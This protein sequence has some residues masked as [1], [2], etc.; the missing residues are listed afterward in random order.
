MEDPVRSLI[1]ADEN[2]D[3]ARLIRRE[4]EDG[5]SL[6]VAHGEQIDINSDLNL[7]RPILIFDKDCPE[8]G[9]GKQR[10]LANNKIM[11][12]RSEMSPLFLFFSSFTL[13]APGVSSRLFFPVYSVS[14][15]YL[16]TSFH[17]PC[18]YS[19]SQ[20]QSDLVRVN[21][22]THTSLFDIFAR[23]PLVF[24]SGVASIYYHYGTIPPTSRMFPPRPPPPPP[25]SQA[26]LT[27][28]CTPR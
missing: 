9:F 23:R 15:L 2:K 21:P 14:L 3:L 8:F 26:S 20:P 12:L 17:S 28:D 24:L 16:T 11:T 4:R 6:S 1:W 7:G 22:L 5:Q 18:N 10:S 19:L 25:I 27:D 13:G